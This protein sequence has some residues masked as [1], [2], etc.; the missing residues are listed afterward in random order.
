MAAGPVVSLLTI[1]LPALTL[2]TAGKQTRA[3]LRASPAPFCLE[4]V[5]RHPRHL[6]YV[7]LPCHFSEVLLPDPPLRIVPPSSTIFGLPCFVFLWLASTNRLR[8]T[9]R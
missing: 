7:L 1:R 6:L 5:W 2:P 9:L 4:D 8:N 3:L